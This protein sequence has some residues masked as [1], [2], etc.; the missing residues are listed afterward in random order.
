MTL[1][2]SL[3]ARGAVP[4]LSPPLCR[5]CPACA[6]AVAGV[7]ARSLDGEKCSG[8]VLHPGALTVP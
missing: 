6:W 4:P 2:T 1:S 8:K 7:G 3:H 5:L